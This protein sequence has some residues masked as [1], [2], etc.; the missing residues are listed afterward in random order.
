M[1]TGLTSIYVSP[2]SFLFHLTESVRCVF[3]ASDFFSQL[4]TMC[5]KIRD[6]GGK[7]DDTYETEAESADLD[8]DPDLEDGDE[9]DEEESDDSDETIEDEL[10]E[11]YMF[12]ESE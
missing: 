12:G 2:M 11:Q 8:I 10:F 5:T 3:I 7:E 9:I 4:P 6:E 1:S